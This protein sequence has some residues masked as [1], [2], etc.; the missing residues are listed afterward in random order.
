VSLLQIGGVE[1]DTVNKPQRPIP[2]GLMTMSGAVWRLIF[3]CGAMCALAWHGSI[4][5]HAVAINFV[6]VL[7]YHLGWGDQWLTKSLCVGLMC[8]LSLA[9]IGHMTANLLQHTVP[10]ISTI[11]G[12]LG[13]MITL[14]ISAQDF[15]DVAGD[16]AVGRRTLPVAVGDKT[17]RAVIS[18]LILAVSFMWAAVIGSSFNPWG[19]SGKPV[20]F[21][22]V[23]QG[24]LACWLAWHT[25]AK[26]SNGGDRYI[27]AGYTGL[28][29]CCMFTP[30]VG[31][32]LPLS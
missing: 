30:I 10:A 21:L 27:F 4:F 25:M 32:W 29:A 8:E 7:H 15:K 14:T 12:F 6:L 13:V 1:E 19:L 5:W 18:G 26:D 23:L 9:S 20:Q 28:I 22:L 3:F 11:S 16:V 24:A 31:L 17:A 2:S